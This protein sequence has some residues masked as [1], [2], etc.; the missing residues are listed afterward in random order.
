M[1]SS[2]DVQNVYVSYSVQII[3]LIQLKMKFFFFSFSLFRAWERNA[4][5]VLGIQGR[6]GSLYLSAPSSHSSNHKQRQGMG[7]SHSQTA[8][9]IRRHG[10]GGRY[11]SEPPDRYRNT[12]AT[13]T[14]LIVFYRQSLWVTVAPSNSICLCVCPAFMVISW[15]L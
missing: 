1:T 6:G 9:S 3:S 15:L 8:T 13:K 4:P 10:T 12:T 11:H 5:T 7:A 2:I 14:F